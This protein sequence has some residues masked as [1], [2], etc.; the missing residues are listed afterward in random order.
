MRTRY[1]CVCMCMCTPYVCVLCYA[2]CCVCDARLGQSHQGEEQGS[3]ASAYYRFKYRLMR[4]K[5]EGLAEYSTGVC[6]HSVLGTPHRNLGN[7]PILLR[8]PSALRPALRSAAQLR[9]TTLQ[10]RTPSLLLVS[11]IHFSAFSHKEEWDPGETW[12]LVQPFRARPS[13]L[14]P[15]TSLPPSHSLSPFGRHNHHGRKNRLLVPEFF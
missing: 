8:T 7:T 4:G 2:V 12:S 11:F 9:P 6:M 3:L 5:G 1:V 15:H 14:S 13:F 10:L